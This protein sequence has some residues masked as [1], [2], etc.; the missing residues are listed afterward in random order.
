[1]PLFL[2]GT[3][4]KDATAACRSCHLIELHLQIEFT[5]VIND[6]KLY[7]CAIAI[8][9]LVGCS[10]EG[11]SPD[12]DTTSNQQPEASAITDAV[13]EMSSQSDTMDE[14]IESKVEPSIYQAAVV[15]ARR[16]EKDKERDVNRKPA[17]IM[18]FF[19]ITNGQRV[20]DMASGPGYYTR[21]ISEIV[22]P[23]GTVV[24]QN[25][26]DAPFVNDKFKAML[27]TQYAD[28]SNVELTYDPVEDMAL[29]DNSVDAM[30]LFLVIHHW[31][32]SEDDGE[33]IP[34]VSAT[35]YANIMRML[36][37][38]GFFGV[39]E[40]LAAEGMSREVSAGIHRIPRETAVADVTSAGLILD[41]ESDL[42]ADHP[43]DDITTYW[44][45]KTPRGM[46]NR[47]VHLYRKPAEQVAP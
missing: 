2:A 5:M 21:I 31:H 17:E 7:I 34:A 25:P 43:D 44:R 4:G 28:Y 36:K 6:T 46:T 20:V 40:H 33:V 26:G 16:P 13:E 22:G 23:E 18:E 10:Q 42:L 39:I 29:P 1:M 32:Y 14:Q 24:A 41:G 8:F 12:A 38:G 19:G 37:P 47:I 35:R 45:D 11:S 9:A 3:K 27:D 15:S 30:F